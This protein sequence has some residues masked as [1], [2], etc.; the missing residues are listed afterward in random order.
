MSYWK[1]LSQ[2]V[3]PLIILLVEVEHFHSSGSLSYQY[4]NYC[5]REEGGK[6]KTVS[7]SDFH[8]SCFMYLVS[9]ILFH[10]SFF[11]YLVSCILFHESCPQGSVLGLALFSLYMLPPGRVIRKHSIDFHCYADDTQLLHF[12]VTRGF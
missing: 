6:G 12:C 7:T 2:T 8:A 10:V 11:M 1:A 9:C 3:A 4:C 5:I